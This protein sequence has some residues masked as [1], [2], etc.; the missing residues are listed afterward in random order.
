MK[1]AKTKLDLKSD[2]QILVDILKKYPTDQFI[3]RQSK[4]QTK[5]VLTKP[6]LVLGQELDQYLFAKVRLYPKSV[7]LTIQAL[8]L[9]PILHELIPTTLQSYWTGYQFKLASVTPKL[10]EGVRSLL[11]LSHGYYYDQG[12]V[13]TPP[14]VPD[15]SLQPFNHKFH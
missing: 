13:K 2:Y 15:N 10:R 14:S 9:E 8:T 12:W 6:V 1:Q 4:T 3:C 11:I 5:L 7:S